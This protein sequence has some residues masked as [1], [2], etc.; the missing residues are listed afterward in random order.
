[1]MHLQ[2]VMDLLLK[3]V[4]GVPE[5]RSIEKKRKNESFWRIIAFP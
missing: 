1:M 4:R 3:A 5:V 2:I